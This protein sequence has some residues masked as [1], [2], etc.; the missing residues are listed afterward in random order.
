[1]SRILK[2]AL[3]GLLA[4]ATLAPIASA[5]PRFFVRGYFGPTF[6]GPAWYGP[7]W[8]GPYGYVPGPNVGKVK[9]ETKMKNAAV[10][11]DGGYAGTVG[12]LKTFPLRPGNHNIELR[13]PD[14]HSFFQER[15][16]VIAG[17]TAK[18]IPGY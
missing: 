14:G 17:K 2:L 1:M 6:Y 12:Q 5:S 7:A 3:T 11:V 10:F 16:M 9:I 4:L 15:I 18:I 13:G 8:V